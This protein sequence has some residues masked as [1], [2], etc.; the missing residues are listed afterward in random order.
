MERRQ[1]M[2]GIALSLGSLMTLPAW[3]SGW[4]SATI[5]TAAMTSNETLLAEL[6]DTLIPTTNTLGAKDLGVHQFIQKMLA[7]CYAKQAQANFEQKLAEIGPLSIKAFGKPFAEGDAAQRLNLLQDLAKSRDKDMRDFYQT[8]RGLTIKGYTN[9][10][11]YRTKF[12][13][14][15]M[16]PARFYGCVPVKNK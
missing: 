11:Y 12:T 16:A 9:S 15:E 7:D 6:V 4:Q 8:L 5:G 14:Y 1:A 13:D 10:E 2:K 3:A